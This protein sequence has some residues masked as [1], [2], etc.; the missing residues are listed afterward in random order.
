[1]YFADPQPD[2]APTGVIEASCFRQVEFAG[3]LAGTPHEQEA[4]QLIDFLLSSHLPGGRAADDV[5]LPGA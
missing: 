5:R 4:Q 2:T 1:V 3:I